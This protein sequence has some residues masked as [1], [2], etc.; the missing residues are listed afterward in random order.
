MIF[1]MTLYIKL[2]I[3]L[4]SAVKPWLIGSEMTPGRIHTS[5]HSLA[6]YSSL[7][8]D[9]FFLHI[10]LNFEKIVFSL[11]LS[12]SAILWE[13]SYHWCLLFSSSANI[14]M[15][16]SFI[17]DRCYSAAMKYFYQSLYNITIFN[18]K[19]SLFVCVW[20]ITLPS[21]FGGTNYK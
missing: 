3:K 15:Y 2:T 19:T 16:H 8:L 20:N 12:V 1:T 10:S 17:L 7:Q 11:T 13:L 4:C 21:V 18:L 6:W 9:F 5:T 14:I